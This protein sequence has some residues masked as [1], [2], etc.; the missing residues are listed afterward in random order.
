MKQQ[1][2]GL[3]PIA[4]VANGIQLIGMFTGV[5]TSGLNIHANTGPNALLRSPDYPLPSAG[6]SPAG[7]PLTSV[8]LPMGYTSWRIDPSNA[9]EWYPILGGYP[10]NQDYVYNNDPANLGGVIPSGGLEIDG[11]TYAAGTYVYQFCDFSASFTYCSND[12][13][14]PSLLYR[15]CRFRS[16]VGA[17]G[18]LN[19]ESGYPGFMAS[20]YCDAGGTGAAGACIVAFDMDG[21]GEGCRFLRNYISYYTTA[22]QPNVGITGFSDSIENFC[23]KVTLVGSSHLNGI[24]LNGGN[25]NFLVQ[26][27]H[28]VQV[29]PDENGVVIDQTDCIAMF[30]DFG[31]FPGT[32]TN[33]DGST[34]YWVTSNYAG[35]TGYAFYLGQNDGTPAGSVQNE[36]FLDNLVTTQVW[37]NGG[38]YG[39]VATNPP[40][41]QYGNVEDGNVWADGSTAGAPLQTPAAQYQFTDAFASNAITVDIT[42]TA[43]DTLVAYIAGYVNSNTQLHLVSVA[44]SAANAWTFSTAPAHQN[45]P[46]NGCYDDVEDYY[47]FSAI[48]YCVDAAAVSSVTVTLNATCNFI[49][50]GVHELILTPEAY[51]DGAA[52]AGT[53]LT[54]INTFTTPS[55]TTT[56]QNDVIVATC[57]CDD[58]WLQT[59]SPPR[60]YVE[61]GSG[62]VNVGDGVVFAPG[63]YGVTFSDSPSSQDVQGVCILALAVG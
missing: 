38:Y 5:P 35:G 27:N 14:T 43:G 25:A 42:T 11:Y 46:A 28:I 47:G 45:P 15:G 9:Q 30:Q 51:A 31:T 13:G 48:G 54:G 58:G 18:F 60:F 39:P 50:V 61:N 24:S 40:W 3:Q 33:S 26:R 7:S 49:G 4:P 12:P 32:G 44:D 22:I 34:G 41:G 59:S 36:H 19:V 37:D 57:S 2:A 53:L 21:N 62:I 63:S 23:E 56:Q 8:P 1:V 16:A 20:H 52:S 6:A 10:I 29:T 55:V 17:P